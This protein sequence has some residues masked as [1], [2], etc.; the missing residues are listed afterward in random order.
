MHVTQTPLKP[1]TLVILAFLALVATAALPC[2]VVEEV[3]SLGFSPCEIFYRYGFYYFS[4]HE[5]YST[6]E[7]NV[8]FGFSWSM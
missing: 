5:S 8:G 2:P 6:L 4:I 7:S 1:I 3:Y